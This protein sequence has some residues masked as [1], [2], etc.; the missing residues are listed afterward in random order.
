MPR[1]LPVVAVPLSPDALKAEFRAA[2]KDLLLTDPEAGTVEVSPSIRA[3]IVARY[4]AAREQLG[5][6]W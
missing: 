4:D 3:E 6:R 5:R 2:R 1:P